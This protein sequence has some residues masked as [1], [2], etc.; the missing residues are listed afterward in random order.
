MPR[1][2]STDDVIE[3]TTKTTNV[4]L[5]FEVFAYPPLTSNPQ[6][7]VNN[8]YLSSKWHVIYKSP[9]MDRI[10]H[11]TSWSHFFIEITTED[12][13]QKDN[14]DYTVTVNNKCSSSNKTVTIIGK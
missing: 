2:N 14:G 9:N 13:M 11:F 4:S 6:L 10:I 1:I 12:F 8:S 5:Y 7:T 3:V